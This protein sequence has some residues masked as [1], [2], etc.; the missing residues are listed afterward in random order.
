MMTLAGLT[1]SI[2]YSTTALL[3]TYDFDFEIMDDDDLVVTLAGTILTKTTNYSVTIESD[4]TGSI[5][6]VADPGD[7]ARLVILR[8]TAKTQA[9]DYVEGDAFPSASHEDA[10]DKLTM[11]I[12]DLKGGEIFKILTSTDATPSVAG[13][14]QF[15]T[16]NFAATII[17][18]FDDG[19][20]GQKIIVV[21]R[22]N[23]TTI[24]FTGTPL[25]GNGGVD[26][27]PALGDWM[28]AVYIGQ[29]WYCAI[30]DCTA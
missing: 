13:Y 6:L 23:N 12:Q 2:V 7:A 5:T 27:I 11:Q 20:P 14:N 4:R 30:H 22:D 29:Y 3:Y 9:T 1:N 10:L 15:A 17:T 24:D 19:V 18:N 8:N 25:L 28:E 21:F 16:L 26:W